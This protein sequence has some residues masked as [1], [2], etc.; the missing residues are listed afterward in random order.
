MTEW[1]QN[2]NEVRIFITGKTGVGKSTLIN[3]LIGAAVAKEGGML[4]PETTEVKSYEKEFDLK[5]DGYVKVTVLDSPG[6]QD[7]TSNEPWYLTNIKE[8]CS[9]I[10]ICIYCVS[11]METRFFKGCADITAIK[12]LTESLGK[13]M[14]ENALF[15]LTFANLAEDS[16]SQ[17]LD[18]DDEEKTKLFQ[19]KIQL[20]KNKLAGALVEEAGLDEETANGI[21]V[22]PAGHANVPALLDRHHWLSPFWFATV[23]AMKPRAQ[24]AMIK[25]N[26]HRIVENP[27]EVRSED[28]QKFVHEQ[29]IIFSERGAL[30][31]AKHGEREIGKEIGSAMGNDASTDLKLALERSSDLKPNSRSLLSLAANLGIKFLEIVRYLIIGNKD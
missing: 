28:L 11:M 13:E 2:S 3:G 4:D 20:W 29:P 26:T 23:H 6:L 16:D 18:A 8:K 15:V 7:G 21:I 19:D 31:G 30:I 24:P 27:K 17:I 25:L 14:W 10:D 9:G 5:E 1:F 22:V 12:K